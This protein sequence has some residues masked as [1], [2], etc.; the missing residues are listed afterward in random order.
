MI[1]VSDAGITIAN[2][3]GASITLTGPTISLN[4]GAMEIT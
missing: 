3:K 1:L 2:G 4:D